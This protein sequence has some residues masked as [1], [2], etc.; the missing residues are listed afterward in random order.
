MALAPHATGTIAQALKGIDFPCGKDGLVDYARQQGADPDAVAVLERL[1]EQTY[2]SMSAVFHAVGGT[3]R[4]RPATPL[5]EAPQ[6]HPEVKPPQRQAGEPRTDGPGPQEAIA[7]P[8]DPWSLWTDMLS[9]WT[10]MNRC[11]M[12]LWFPWLR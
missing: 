11:L 6:P 10:E 2:D 12:N 1:P 5:E 4:R 7:P 9:Q 3:G 8:G